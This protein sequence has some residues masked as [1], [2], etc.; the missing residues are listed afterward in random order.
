MQLVITHVSYAAACAVV[1]LINLFL[2]RD[3]SLNMTVLGLGIFL[4]VGR[5]KFGEKQALIMFGLAGVSVLILFFPAGAIDLMLAIVSLLVFAAIYFLTVPFGAHV[6]ELGKQEA[7]LKGRAEA[8]SRLKS[9]G[10]QKL[11]EQDEETDV[12]IKEISSI[13][14][15]VKE[16]SSSLTLESSVNSISDIIKKIVKTNFKIPLDDINFIIIFKRE[17]E[18]YIAGTFGFDEEAIKNAE[19]QVVASILRNVAKN[20]DVLYLPKIADAASIGGMSFIKSV[21]YMPFYAEKK[22]LGV[23]LISGIR[24]DIFTERQIDSLRVLAN[25]IAITM[26]K[27]HLYEEVQAMSVNDGLTGLTVHRHFQEKLEL[28]L[29]RTSRYGGNLSVVMADIDFFKKINDTYG[30]LAGDFILK[31]IALIFKNH[32]APTDI[33]ARYGGEEFIIVYPETEKDMA[34]MKAVKIRKDIES[35]KFMFNNQQIKVTMSMGVAGYPVDGTTR[36][37]LIEKA[38]QAL[39]KAKEEGRNRVIKAS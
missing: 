9:V 26:E 38:D 19:K 18:Y 11:I 15:A 30:H 13:Y 28:E 1:Y 20:E 32:T 31:T 17:F 39:Y 33:V 25:Q 2:L 8:L 12:E 14:T 3:P 6:K 16:L 27:V 4:I 10:M 29:K 24:E 35:Y 7:A 5:Q 22:L 36:R 21:A 23:A 34:H 37:S